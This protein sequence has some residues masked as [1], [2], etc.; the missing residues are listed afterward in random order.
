MAEKEALCGPYALFVVKPQKTTSSV[1]IDRSFSYFNFC[2]L[3]L[4]MIHQ[5]AMCGCSVTMSSIQWSMQHQN[6]IGPPRDEMIVLSARRKKKNKM[7]SLSLSLCWSWLMRRDHKYFFPMYPHTHTNNTRGASWKW[8]AF[9]KVTRA[10]P[11]VDGPDLFEYSCNWPSW[12][13]KTTTTSHKRKMKI[14]CR[15]LI[16]RVTKRGEKSFK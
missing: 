9:S 16:E 5:T 13:L 2:I 6:L 14:C 12:K 7:E 3:P 10:W 8:C 1:E 11:R 15:R 4:A